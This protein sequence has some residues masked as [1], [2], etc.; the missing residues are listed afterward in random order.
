MGKTYEL[1]CL[2]CYKNKN[3]KYFPYA[4]FNNIIK[5]HI[6]Y[7]NN[8]YDN[9]CIKIKNEELKEKY[10][11]NCENILNIQNFEINNRFKCGYAHYC[12][13]CIMN[14][15][16]ETNIIA[17]KKKTKG[18]NDN[19]F[20]NNKENIIKNN[21][22]RYSLNK[23]IYN[24]NRR[25][26]YNKDDEYKLKKIISSKIYRD[27]QN[28]KFKLKLKKQ[29]RERIYLKNNMNYR[30]KKRINSNLRSNLK[31]INLVKNQKIEKY[32]G[33]DFIQFK[34][35]IEFQFTK[36]INW[37]N[38]SSWDLD[39]VLPISYF[40][41]TYNSDSLFIA[42]NWINLRPLKRIDNIRK[43]NKIDY[44]LYNIQLEKSKIFLNN[45]KINN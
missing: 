32:I 20:K 41:K 16:K 19:Y 39:H 29:H 30:L 38:M 1:T 35:W 21:K 9:I 37:N 3:H 13:E 34:K 22:E 25:L 27:N 36:E 6:N 7:C 40:N 14:L 8:C 45:Y 26:K 10:C 33:C 12:R 44:V 4:R 17:E 43:N 24:A 15:N 28:N 31:K 5:K 11:P 42:F 2:V 23:S 18:Y